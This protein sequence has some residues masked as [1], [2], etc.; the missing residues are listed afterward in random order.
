MKK[1]EFTEKQKRF[2]EEYVKDLNGTR[3]AIRA[4]YSERSA[5]QSANDLLSEPDI[6]QYVSQLQ[7][8]I[9]KKLK[10]DAEWVLNRFVEISDRC[11][12]AV[13]VMIFDP[14]TKEYVESGE[15]KFDSNGANKATELVAKHIGFF[16]KDNKQQRAVFKIGYGN[17]EDRD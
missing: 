16:E 5:R 12:Q 4:G 11:M 10:I 1:K 13:P 3:A 8:E 2:C 6:K 9:S 7:S 17:R 15:Y 14:E